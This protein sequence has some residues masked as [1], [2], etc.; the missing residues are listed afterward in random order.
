MSNKR[1]RASASL[2]KKIASLR[3]TVVEEPIVFR[4][5]LSYVG[6]L[7]WTNWALR[8]AP[9]CQF[10]AFLNFLAHR[11]RQASSDLAFFDSSVVV[12]LQVWLDLMRLERLVESFE[13]SPPTSEP[14]VNEVIFSDASSVGLGFVLVSESAAVRSG[15]FPLEDSALPIFAR[16]TLALLFSLA[17]CP[18]RGASINAAVDNSNLFFSALKGHSAAPI[19]N[20]LLCCI[21]RLLSLKRSSLSLALVPS[22]RELADAVSRLKALPEDVRPYMANLVFTKVDKTQLV[23][24][25]FV[26]ALLAGLLSAFREFAVWQLSPCRRSLLKKEREG[27]QLAISSC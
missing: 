13:F 22:E 24:T 7:L 3:P 26:D 16:E 11:M 12:P 25:A 19:P 6:A 9:L 27:E 8:A 4:V 2:R 1:C 21:F 10:E 17:A 23:D 15:F 20:A 14:D 18:F 5:F